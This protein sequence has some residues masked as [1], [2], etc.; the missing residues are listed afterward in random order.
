MRNLTTDPTGPFGPVPELQD[1]RASGSCSLRSTFRGTVNRIL[2]GFDGARQRAE[3]ARR[4]IS[5][6]TAALGL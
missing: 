6:T 2:N 1:Q 3:R 5:S 4:Q